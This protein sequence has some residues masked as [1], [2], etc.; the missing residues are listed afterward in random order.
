[1]CEIPEPS[2]WPNLQPPGLR[3]DR[4]TSYGLRRGLGGTAPSPVCACLA[5]P[6]RGPGDLGTL[7]G[8]PPSSCVTSGKP[9]RVSAPHLQRRVT[10]RTAHGGAKMGGKGVGTCGAARED[11]SRKQHCEPQRGERGEECSGR[12]ER[13]ADGVGG[14]VR[15][16]STR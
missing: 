3:W 12:Q 11:T 10:G 5:R 6:R 8:P 14:G 2:R 4:A 13:A 9:G 16:S 15:K 7:L 1:M